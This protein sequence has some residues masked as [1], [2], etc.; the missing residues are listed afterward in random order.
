[1]ML[2]CVLFI[3]PLYFLARKKWLGFLINSVFYGMACGL[4]LTL[5][6]IFVAPLFWLIAVFHA[7][8]YW[9]REKRI[10]D[11]ELLA[12]KMAEKMREI[13]KP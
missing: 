13:Q 3:P 8:Y 7:S 12:T 10:Q 5:A 6:L 4:V 9:R 1:M 2:L 11:A